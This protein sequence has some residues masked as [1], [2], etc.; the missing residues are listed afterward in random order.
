MSD[1]TFGAAAR[2]YWDDI[3]RRD[4]TSGVRPFFSRSAGQ[5]RYLVRLASG[6]FLQTASGRRRTFK[7]I[8]D[9]QAALDASI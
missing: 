4:R 9:A 7:T 8:A 1:Q 5:T 3:Q 6:D 2:R